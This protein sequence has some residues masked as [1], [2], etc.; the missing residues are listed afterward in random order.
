M[1]QTYTKVW[2]QDGIDICT[3]I[4]NE[5]TILSM[6]G[7]TFKRTFVEV[8][9]KLLEKMGQSWNHLNLLDDRPHYIVVPFQKVKELLLD[10]R[11]ANIVRIEIVAFRLLLNLLSLVKLVLVATS[12]LAD[13]LFETLDVGSLVGRGLER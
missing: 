3:E 8:I 9:G 2:G 10:V 7:S 6:P 11:R 5:H 13:E 4:S 12:E 1:T